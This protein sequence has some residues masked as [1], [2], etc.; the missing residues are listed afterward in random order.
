MVK[1]SLGSF[2][3]DV[4][5][6]AAVQT[7]RELGDRELLERFVAAKDE[8]A[9]AVLVERHGRTVLAACRR[10]LCSTHDAE[11]ACQ[12][13][14]LVLAQKAGSIRKTTS[15]PSWLHGV[16][17]RV[18]AH[19]RREHG[20]R[21]KREQQGQT[22]AVP[23]P[24]AEVSW[25]EVQAILDEELERLPERLRAPLILC[26]LDGRT[27]DEAAAQLGVR[28]A[29]LHGRLERGRKALC[30]RL[31]KRGVA[32][33]TA[34]LATAIGE[35]MARAAVSPAAVLLTARAAVL[36]TS[37]GTVGP[38]PVS[39]KVLSLAQEVARNM[40]LTKWKLGISA[41]LC[42]SLLVTALGGSLAA[43]SAG[44]EK[45]PPPGS[46]QTAA[47]PPAKTAAP[48]APAGPADA[49]PPA[50]QQRL[51]G[52]VLDPAGKPVAGAKL[53]LLRWDSP[54]WL[55]HTTETPPP[56]VLAE[57][58]KDGRFSFSM[59]RSSGELFT[60]AAGFAPG[61][62]IGHSR[63]VRRSDDPP[64]TRPVDDS[65]VLRLARDDVPVRG[66][67]L[68]LQGQPV[69]GATIRV[70]G[71]TAFADGRLDTWFETLKN[72]R[73]GQNLPEDSY[74]SSFTVDGLSH[75][76]PA[77]T[78]DKDGRFEIKGVG[79]ERIVAFTVEAPTIETRVVHVVTRPSLATGD[80]RIPE[81]SMVFANGEVKDL[82]LKP[83]YPPTFTHV[84]EPCRVI[85]GVVRDQTTGKPIAGA[86]VRGDQ[87]VRYPLYYNRT[88]TDKDGHYRLTGLPLE[89]RVVG[90]TSLVAVPPK[91]EPYMGLSRRLPASKDTQQATF[92]FA[93][94]RGVWIEGQV[95]DKATG[96]GVVAR[97]EYAVLAP[98]K[99]DAGP[100]RVPPGASS[101]QPYYRDP[102]AADNQTD[103]D[104]NF[105]ILAAPER[106]VVG[107]TACGEE[108]GHYRL[109]VG[110]DKIEGA[111]NGDGFIPS[112]GVYVS[113]A[114]TVTEI[115]PAKGATGMR[116][117]LLLDPGRAQAIGVRGP[118]GKPLDGVRV[119]GQFARDKVTWTGW[120]QKPLP[121]E[122]TVYGL[123]PGQGRT[124]LLEHPEKQLAARCDLPGDETGPI[125]VTLQPAATVTGRLVDD[126]G[127]PRPQ[128]DITVGFLRPKGQPLQHSH[129]FRTDAEG[130]FRIDGLI[131]GVAYRGNASSL[132]LYGQLI[133]D[134][135]ALQSGEKKE[136]GDVKA[137]RGDSQ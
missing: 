62:E 100:I 126:E 74:P 27:R 77:I 109:Q 26:Y 96:R 83:Y 106:G 41:L 69:A 82:R 34:L 36:L 115:K 70:F 68:D 52:R 131:P 35:G 79:R 57:T 48:A 111:F 39:T 112:P 122:F 125:T 105:R 128:V 98:G 90:S 93:L 87:P 59:A 13:A 17:V 14:F 20:R 8:A 78:S 86:V 89:P 54:P 88:F 101:G 66:R 130:K 133:F 114:D 3:Q 37:G 97:L 95:K 67:L 119:H 16:A 107:A 113:F 4:C 60:T 33:S 65:V 5:K 104:G 81:A 80:I 22:L 118:D 110:L 44:Q 99:V 120:S 84:A 61:W 18:A 53:Y 123:D 129:T 49:A 45:T 58:D 85:S 94:P 42:A 50:E 46:P 10:M 76:F 136:L 63:S 116:C 137:K 32:L 47:D 6:L 117:D 71:L 56:K 75:F 64:D 102:Y 2:L 43:V 108:S 30:E 73:P 12:T 25:R 11:D 127:R 51:S 91:G 72:R 38:G 124:L 92:D 7:A 24:A 1:K 28:V 29:C 121:A 103:K 23:D 31:T 21:C 9:F 40:L 134:N 135:L 19:V 15:L 55:R 132:G